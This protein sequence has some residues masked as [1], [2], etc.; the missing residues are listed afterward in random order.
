LSNEKIEQMIDNVKASLA[1]EGLYVTED[2]AEIFKKYLE[3][4]LTEKD[5][6][7]IIK[8]SKMSLNKILHPGMYR[9]CLLEKGKVFE[10]RVT[11]G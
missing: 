3:G 4:A 7:E 2:E 11:N 1:I 5:V 6:L 9:G 8:G 10:V